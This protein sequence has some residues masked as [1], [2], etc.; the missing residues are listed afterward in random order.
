[1]LF[2][3]AVVAEV[4]PV[5]ALRVAAVLVGDADQLVQEDGLP[6]AVAVHAAALARRVHRGAH[7]LGLRR[8][9][10]CFFCLYLF[11]LICCFNVVICLCSLKTS[12]AL[13]TSMQ[14]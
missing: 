6:P 12:K 4:Q 9:N 8:R 13:C 3:S 14:M 1:M 5:A 10:S 7:A 11:L 2:R